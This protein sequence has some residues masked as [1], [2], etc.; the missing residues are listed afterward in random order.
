MTR[1]SSVAVRALMMAL[2]V[3]M[4]VCAGC[5]PSPTTVVD[6]HVVPQAFVDVFVEN[7]DEVAWVDVDLHT[8]VQTREAVES[9]F[10]LAYGRTGHPRWF[11]HAFDVA[12]LDFIVARYAPTGTARVRYVAERRLRVKRTQD[13]E[14]ALGVGDV[15]FSY[16]RTARVVKEGMSRREVTTLLGPPELERP[17]AGRPGAFDLRYPSFC[18]R[19]V[20]GK[21]AH[22][23]PREQCMAEAPSR[24]SVPKPS[25]RAPKRP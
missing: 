15:V 19:F 24:V 17:V 14:R 8:A 10:K 3:V 16:E 5:A 23:D 2:T 21:V 22:V 6:R 18:V 20:G 9:E 1:V 13:A 25:K 4:P 7:L 11:F 12:N